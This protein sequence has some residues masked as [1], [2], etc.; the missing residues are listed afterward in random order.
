MPTASA[1][2]TIPQAASG[3]CGAQ[4]L[5]ATL[6]S[7]A[8]ALSVRGRKGEQESLDLTEWLDQ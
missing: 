1:Q 8:E 3:G 7:L 5:D 6:A 2:A 4:W